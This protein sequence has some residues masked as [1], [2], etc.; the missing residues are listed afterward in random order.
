MYNKFLAP[1]GKPGYKDIYRSYSI[2][3]IKSLKVINLE[4]Y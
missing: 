1:A 4:N 3:N 2:K